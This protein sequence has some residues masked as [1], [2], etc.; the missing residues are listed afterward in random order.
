MVSAESF[1]AFALEFTYIYYAVFLALACLILIAA[2]IIMGATQGFKNC[3]LIALLVTLFT[4]QLVQVFYEIAM[5]IDNT[6]FQIAS[7]T[8]II[9]NDTLC[10]WLVTQTYI[11]VA[12]ETN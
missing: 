6:D 9:F 7:F 3:N 11:K 4:L 10:H 5:L 8:G 12:F 1:H 2:F